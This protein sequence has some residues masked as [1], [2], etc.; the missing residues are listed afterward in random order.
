M[1]K[2]LA[3]IILVIML[4]A[5]SYYAFI[6]YVPYSEG[7]RS[8]ELIK[9]SYKGV[10]VKTWEGEISQGISGAQIFTFSVEDKEKQVIKDLEKFQGRYVK[11]TYKER[12]GTFFWLGDTKY[13]V[14]K[15]EEEQSPHFKRLIN[16]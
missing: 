3:L 16:E 8:G 1:K 2:I 15:V 7:V 14:T 13:F 4:M 6:Y 12:F 11:V 10:A 5:A 9:I